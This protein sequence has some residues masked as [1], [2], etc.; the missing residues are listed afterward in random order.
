MQPAQRGLLFASFAALLGHF[1]WANLTAEDLGS[2]PSARNVDSRGRQLRVILRGQRFEPSRIV[3]TDADTIR[4]ELESG[5]PHNVAFHPDSI[6]SGALDALARNLKTDP[7]NLFTPDMLLMPGESIL[8]PLTG[9]PP[10]R[11][12][13]YCAPHYGGRMFG[14]F[15]IEGASSGPS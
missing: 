13:F 10:G 15:V 3:A 7:R 6:P 4:F 9:L 11:Y 14:E 8:L 12:F 1:P 2:A 5:A